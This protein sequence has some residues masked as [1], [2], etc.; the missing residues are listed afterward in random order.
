MQRAPLALERREGDLHAAR[1]QV[2]VLGHLRLEGGRDAVQRL[3]QGGLTSQERPKEA[4]HEHLGPPR[5]GL[6]GALGVV[7]RGHRLARVDAE[8]RG[9]KLPHCGHKPLG[10]A[11]YPAVDVLVVRAP[12][13]HRLEPR[14]LL[15]QLLPRRPPLDVLHDHL[16]ICEGALLAVR[17]AHGDV[18][19]EVPA[20]GRAD[21]AQHLLHL[22][23]GE[24][25]GP[26][27]PHGELHQHEARDPDE[28]VREPVH[29]EPPQ[30]AMVQLPALR[31]RL[32]RPPDHDERGRKRAHC[33]GVARDGVGPHVAREKP[34][35][36]VEDGVEP[37]GVLHHLDEEVRHEPPEDGALHAQDRFG[38]GAPDVPARDERHCNGRVSRQLRP[39]I[40]G[41]ARGYAH[42]EKLLQGCPEA[43]GLEPQSHLQGSGGLA[44]P[45]SPEHAPAD[46]A[47][48]QHR[49]L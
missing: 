31:A 1:P 6:H 2:E 42:G 41:D 28:S 21:V 17:A 43:R 33:S 46:S 40:D 30:L 44:L 23:P 22:C 34:P 37:E 26:L 5:V 11:H 10:G 47:P 20:E 32:L 3:H 25:R 7:L 15:E 8:E 36:A 9:A 35:E 18:G 38:K 49:L 45:Q 4:L 14:L 27:R 19:L 29:G 13:E 39:H 24:R 12:P 48:G 16:G